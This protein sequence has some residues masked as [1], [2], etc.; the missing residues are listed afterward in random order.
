MS[1]AEDMAPEIANRLKKLKGKSSVE[2]AWFVNGKLRYK[3]YGDDRVKDLR[4]PN[5]LLNITYNGTINC[6]SMSKI[7]FHA[8]AEESKT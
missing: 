1:I 6:K 4:D 5:D 2:T 7:R 8:R 3:E